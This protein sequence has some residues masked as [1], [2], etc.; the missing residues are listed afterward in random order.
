MQRAAIVLFGIG[1][2]TAATLLACGNSNGGDV[3]VEASEADAANER[4][5]APADAGSDTIDAEPQCVLPGRYGSE[6]CERCLKLRCCDVITACESNPDCKPLNRCN[7]AC[8]FEPDAGGCRF[9][10]E[11][12]FPAGKSGLRAIDQ[13]GA[14]KEPQGCR[15]VCTT[16]TP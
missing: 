5:D 14:N 10:C 6:E 3:P 2:P 7:L 4:G 16:S 9:G 8:R 13:C 11:A 15:D 1:M 12:Q